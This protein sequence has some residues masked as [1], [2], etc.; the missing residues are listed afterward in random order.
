MKSFIAGLLVVLAVITC[1]VAP[2]YASVPNSHVKEVKAI[3]YKTNNKTH[4]VQFLI[5]TKGKYHGHI[6]AEK[7]NRK[8]YKRL[9][10]YKGKKFYLYMNTM[11]TK[12][13]YDDRIEEHQLV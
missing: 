4:T 7:L 5:T 13:I 9:K 6:Y 12:T 11:G 2:T 8:L 1:A 3:M 10:K